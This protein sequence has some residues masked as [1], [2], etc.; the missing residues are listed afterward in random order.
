MTARNGASVSVADG[1]RW[2]VPPGAHQMRVVI[3]ALSPGVGI[4][5]L[6]LGTEPLRASLLLVHPSNGSPDALVRSF[7]GLVRD[8]CPPDQ[9]AFLGVNAHAPAAIAACVLLRFA[10][11]TLPS[12]VAGATP[13][14]RRVL[15]PATTPTEELVRQLAVLSSTIDPSADAWLS[16]RQA[17]TDLDRL[18]ATE[19]TAAPGDHQ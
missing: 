19:A 9:L 8:G 4:D 6:H 1:R 18:L 15:H 3:V 10:G 2:F 12:A 17:C 5:L 16:T 14:L 13:T 11:S 7:R